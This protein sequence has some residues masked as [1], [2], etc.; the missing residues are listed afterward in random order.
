MTRGRERPVLLVHGMGRSPVSMLRLGAALKRDGWAVRYFGYACAV[1]SFDAIA[2]RLTVRLR[3]EPVLCAV[4]HSLGGLLLRAATAQLPHP[5]ARLVMLGTPN[6]SPRWARAM[7]ANPVYRA[8]T[9]DAG[10]LLAQPHRVDALPVPS[11]PTLVIAGDAGPRWPRTPTADVANDLVVA[12]DET[13]L[14]GARHVVLPV[15]HTFM[16]HAPAVVALVRAECR[17]AALD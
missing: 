13:P 7:A 6:K 17:A 4:G 15:R 8:V 3:H 10:Q 9:G 5:P 14:H 16:M 11:M 12:V 2:E 1:Q